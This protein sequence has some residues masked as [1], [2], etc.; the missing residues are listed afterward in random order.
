MTE[1]SR[2]HR[3][4]ATGIGRSQV[5]PAL[6]CQISTEEIIRYVT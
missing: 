6:H 2:R 4:L 5:Q 3:K 1:A